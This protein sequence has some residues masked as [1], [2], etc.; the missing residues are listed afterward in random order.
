MKLKPNT[1]VMCQTK[2]DFTPF[3]AAVQNEKLRKKLFLFFEFLENKHF[4][5]I[6]Q[7]V[8]NNFIYSYMEKLVIIK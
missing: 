8:I 2:L 7:I 3:E 1:V 5:M 4:F 6:S